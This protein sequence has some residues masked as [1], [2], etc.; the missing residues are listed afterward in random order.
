MELGEVIDIAMENGKMP[1][2]LNDKV[3]DAVVLARILAGEKFN[4]TGAFYRLQLDNPLQYDAGGRQLISLKNPDQ[5][6]PIYK[7][8]KRCIILQTPSL[9]RICMVLEECNFN[10]PNK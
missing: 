1:A 10:F 5:V 2:Y 3:S 7:F 4:N 6:W 8:Y 9:G